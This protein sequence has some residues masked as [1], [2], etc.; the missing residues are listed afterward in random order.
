MNYRDLEIKRSYISYG[1]DN[2]ASSLIVPAL[3]CTQLYRRSVGFFSSSVFGL[4]FEGIENLLNNNGKIQLIASPRLDEN[5]MKAIQTGYDVRN[6]IISDC[7]SRDFMQSLDEFDD[8]Q[9]SLLSELV[10]RDV[11]DIKI[12]TVE[13]RDHETG[14]Y[15][16]KLGILQD[17]DNNKIV[18]YGSSNSSKNGYYTNYEKIRVVKSWE[19]GQYESVEDEVNEFARLWNGTN[20]YVKVLDYQESAKRHIIEAL[21]NRNGHKKTEAIELRGYQKEAIQAW[22]DNNYQG[23]FVMATGTGK[24]WTAIYAAKELLKLHPVTIVICAPYKHLVKQ[25]AEDVEKVFEDAMIVMVSSENP[26]WGTEIKQELIAQKHGLSK[27]LIIISTNASFKMKRFSDIMQHSTME[28]LLIADEAHRFKECT[29]ATKLTYQYLLGLSATP[30]SGKTAQ[31]GNELMSFFGGE[32]FRLTLEDAL[33]QH[34]LVPYFYYPIFV[35]ATE[36]EEKTFDKYG[37]LISSCFRNGICLD[38]EKLNV[39]I[40][41]RLRVISMAQ[42]KQENIDNII[43]NVREKDHVVVYCGDGKLY[44]QN[45]GEDIRHIQAVK[46]VLN[47]HGYKASQF[48]AKE[49]MDERMKLVDTFNKGSI[50]ALA[51]IRCLDEGINIPSIKSALILSSNDDYREFVQRR[52]RLLRLYPGKKNATIYDVIV[53]PSIE[54]KSWAIIELRRYNEFAKLAM[55]YD[56]LQERL[57]QLCSDYGI[58]EEELNIYD[59]DDME[60]DTDE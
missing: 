60:D 22:K 36:E 43:N 44:D 58:D 42:E 4:I 48:T 18:F 9:L 39:F 28:K 14:M 12:A 46:Q 27:Q 32:V 29:S 37:R 13:G 19:I 17:F 23:F 38:P 41:A 11:L 15:H 31:S 1:D 21:K 7:F 33:K 6:K 45:S 30:F 56:E 40:R 26:S 53:L 50:T 35:N 5:D 20:P 59:Y 54:N 47:T 16:D 10:A 8:Q 57:S 51:A 52:G 55:N 49:N 2:I 24:T 34:F 25:W 3:E